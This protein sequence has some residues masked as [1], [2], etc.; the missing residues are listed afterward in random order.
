MSKAIRFQESYSRNSNDWSVVE[1]G[2]GR[3]SFV[4]DGKGVSMRVG[5]IVSFLKKN[6]GSTVP[7]LTEH[8]RLIHGSY[9]RA[10]V[11]SPLKRL[12]DS[13]LVSSEGRGRARTYT[14]VSK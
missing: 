1:Q 14:L 11:L 7:Q 4:S 10:D 6:P 13:G 8:L 2:N 5:F 12:V 9:T 3:I